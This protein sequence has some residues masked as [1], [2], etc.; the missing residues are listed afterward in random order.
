MGFFKGEFMDIMNELSPERF[1]QVDDLLAFVSIYD[2]DNRTKAY[3]KML[4]ENQHLIRGAVCVEAGCGFGIFSEFLVKLGAR[5]VYAVE[6]NELLF[7]QAKARLS[8]YNNVELVQCDIQDFKPNEK[9]NVLVQEL[10]GQLLYDED[11]FALDNLKFSPDVVMPNQAALVGACLNSDDF[12]D[13]TVTKKVL[14]KLD[15]CLVSGLFDDE[16]VSVFYSVGL[17]Q[18]GKPTYSFTK[19]ISSLKGDL[20]CFGLQIFNDAKMICETGECDNWSFVWTPRSGDIY[21]LEFV[22]TERGMN[23]YFA[24]TS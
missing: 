20:L 1:E 18:M 14:K 10:F 7:E 11:V 24:W 15:G 2:D 13:N 6:R 9:I 3:K 21:T 22:P 19:D 17:W 4:K 5:K 16:K 12:V 8:R 23:T